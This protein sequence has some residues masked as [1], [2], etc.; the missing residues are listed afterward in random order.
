MT[1]A[2][3]SAISKQSLHEFLAAIASKT[4]TPGGGAAAGAVAAIA[5]ALARMV[6]NYSVG[7]K[8]LAPHEPLLRESLDALDRG[9]ALLLKLA[10]E[11]A[12][13]Y[14]LVNELSRLPE[15]D[16]RR[17][18]EWPAAVRAGMDVP[19]AMIAACVDLL[20][21]FE[22]L[23]G[24]TNPHLRSDLAIAAVLAEAGARS[25]RWNVLVNAP[26]IPEPARAADLANADRMREEAA[27]LATSIESRCGHV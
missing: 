10:D 27:R 15:T 19:L 11:D 8:T 14:G 2:P 5:A 26:N 9:S 7:K 21:R 17:Q 20:R 12:A 23:C 6:V 4:P 13:A 22:S 25:A 24:T 3:D 18:Q 1:S 16:A